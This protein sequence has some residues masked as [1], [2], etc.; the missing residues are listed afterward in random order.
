MWIGVV[1]IRNDAGEGRSLSNRIYEMSYLEG[2][3]TT[4]TFWN[5]VIGW[6]NTASGS[7]RAKQTKESM[8]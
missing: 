6:D 1:D 8:M 2:L 7:K 4:P 3:T 5:R